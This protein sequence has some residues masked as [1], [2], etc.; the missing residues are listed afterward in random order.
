[1][2]AISGRC[3][4]QP[5]KPLRRAPIVGCVTARGNRS[6]RDIRA[7]LGGVGQGKRGCGQLLLAGEQS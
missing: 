6:L 5:R 3:I 2:R 7:G 4:T 1:M